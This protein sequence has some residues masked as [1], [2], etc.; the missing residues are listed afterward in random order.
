[1]IAISAVL[2]AKPGKEAELETLLSIFYVSVNSSPHSIY[3]SKRKTYSSTEKTVLLEAYK[4]SGI[5]KKQ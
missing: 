5:V 1:M 2:K 3:A 4:T